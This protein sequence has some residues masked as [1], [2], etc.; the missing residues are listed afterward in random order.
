VR[1]EA[2]PSSRGPAQFQW[3]CGDL[4]EAAGVQASALESWYD[5]SQ[6]QQFAMSYPQAVHG[7]LTALYRR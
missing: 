5:C 1:L 7:L 4:V 2:S 6:L 3:T